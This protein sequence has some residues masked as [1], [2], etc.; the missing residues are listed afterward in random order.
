ME[1]LLL[2]FSADDMYTL[3]AFI[4]TYIAS[5]LLLKY[6]NNCKVSKNNISFNKTP[7]LIK[8]NINQ[9]LIENYPIQP[10]SKILYT[11]LTSA[12]SGDEEPII[13]F[14]I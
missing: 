6:S 8:S 9:N 12:R 2:L 3:L 4:S 11:R 1:E 5:F 14:S 13:S 7:R 10:I